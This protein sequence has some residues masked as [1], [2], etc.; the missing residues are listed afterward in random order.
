MDGVQCLH[1]S[2]DV[3][4]E[5]GNINPL[6]PSHYFFLLRKCLTAIKENDFKVQSLLPCTDGK[7][8]YSTLTPVLNTS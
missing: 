4:D 2:F 5:F 1:C 6:I 7:R 8:M 3:Q